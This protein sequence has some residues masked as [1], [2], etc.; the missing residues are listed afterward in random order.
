M[1]SIIQI[2]GVLTHSEKRISILL[3]TFMFTAMIFEIIGLGVFI[4]LVY[5]LIGEQSSLNSSIFKDILLNFKFE[6]KKD[7]IIFFA[8]SFGFV[9][10][11]KNLFLIF[12]TWFNNKNLQNLSKRVS[13]QLFKNYIEAPYFFHIKNNSSKLLYNCTDAT[14]VFKE[15]SGHLINL[16][17]EIMVLIGLSF[18]LFY[19][20]PIGFLISSSIMLFIGFVYFRINK[21]KLFQLGKKNRIKSKR[22]NKKF[23]ARIGWN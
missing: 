14:D 8:A 22:K 4:P 1:T 19:F 9:I 23:N 16:F 2:W 11:V 21:N 3:V 6:N 15:A 7:S 12:S 18:F 5:V 17:S 13:Q 10:F 20:E